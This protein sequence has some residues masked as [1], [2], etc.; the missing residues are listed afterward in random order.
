[1]SASDDSRPDPTPWLWLVVLIEIVS[2][3]PALLSVGAV[4]VLLFRPPWLPRLVERLYRT[5]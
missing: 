1:M 3:I 2:P 5:R 4:W